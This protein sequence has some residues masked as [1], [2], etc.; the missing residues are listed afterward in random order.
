ML[1]QEKAKTKWSQIEALVGA[2]PRLE[3]I[4]KDLINHFE[5]RCKTQ[6]GKAMI[7]GMSRDICARLYEELIKLKPEW[8]DSDHMK[9]FIKVVMTASAA[10]E[11]HLQ[12]HNKL[13]FTYKHEGISQ[14]R[15]DVPV[16]T[17]Y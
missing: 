14:I 8:D 5:T 12:K 10:D 2:Q 3:Q 16:K 6:P 1:L 13:S 9:G 11:Q 4:A 17:D 15:M 7:I